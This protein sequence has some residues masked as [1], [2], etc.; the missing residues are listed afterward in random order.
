M[1]CPRTFAVGPARGTQGDVEGRRDREWE[2]PAVR[3]KQGT[4][5]H[6]AERRP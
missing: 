3:A 4:A 1:A 2:A 5:G 6:V